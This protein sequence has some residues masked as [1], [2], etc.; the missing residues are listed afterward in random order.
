MS[1][2]TPNPRVLIV[3]DE[4][5]ITDSLEL[6]F[7]SRGYAVRTAL[8]AESAMTILGEFQ[9]DVAI[10]DVMLPRMS[11]VDLARVL[12][13]RSPGCCVILVS[14]HPS[15]EDLLSQAERQGRTFD[16]LAKPLHPAFLLDR[17]AALLE[18]V[19]VRMEK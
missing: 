9:P 2:L 18:S 8:S 11:G 16:V 13:D 12:E 1:A 15:A 10:V 19:P 7:A 6:I 5:A 14:G 3:D 4:A 17:V